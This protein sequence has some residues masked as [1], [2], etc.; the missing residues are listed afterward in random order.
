LRIVFFGTPQLAVPSLAAVATSHDVVGVV[1][2]PDKPVGRSKKPMPPA[3]KV[4][5]QERGIPVHQPVK[6]HDGAFEA[7]LREKAPDC[8]AIA[9]YGRL[10]KQPVLD[11]PPHGFI[12]MHPSL[13]PKWRGPSPIQSAVI[14]GDL[15]TGVTIMKLTLAMDAGPILL[16]EKTIIGHEETA[17]ELTERLAVMG[18]RLLA[19]A[20]GHVADGTATFTPQ[21]DGDAVFCSMLRKEDGHIDWSRPAHELHDLVRGCQPWP[22][23]QCVFRGEACKIHLSELFDAPHEAAP[24]VVTRVEDDCVYVAAG[25]GQL[26]IRVFQSPGKKAMPMA[27]YLRGHAIATGEQFESKV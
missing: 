14:A 4:W 20:L 22:V 11:V 7:W 18:A 12:N 15:L 13:L 27:D 24:G 5:A 2:Q 21:V 19:D 23:A 10:L 26:G 6:V 1:C 16:Q 25:E 3:V 8:C 17:A 9:A